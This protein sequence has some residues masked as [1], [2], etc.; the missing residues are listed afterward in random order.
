MAIKADI[1]EDFR[2][3]LLHLKTF[4]YAVLGIVI[5]VSLGVAIAAVIS[6]T[7][8]TQLFYD[9]LLPTVLSSPF[10]SYCTIFV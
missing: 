2:Q 4:L 3:V 10:F 8:T 5:V 1:N 6:R 9:S 7:R